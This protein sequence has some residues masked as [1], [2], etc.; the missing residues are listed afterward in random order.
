V[1]AA[2]SASGLA[3]QRLRNAALALQSASVTWPKPPSCR[4]ELARDR[5]AVIKRHEPAAAK[6]GV[7]Q[8]PCN[9]VFSSRAHEHA[10]CPEA[11][12]HVR[13]SA[14]SAFERGRRTTP[15]MVAGMAAQ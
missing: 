12:G 14:G 10:P 15:S 5:H 3:K 13:Y 6:S 9:G 1:P 7:K 4:P 8:K 2:A 11:P